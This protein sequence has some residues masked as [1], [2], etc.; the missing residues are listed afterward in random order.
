MV[1]DGEAKNLIMKQIEIVTLIDGTVHSFNFPSL[2]RASLTDK[3][4][5]FPI[6]P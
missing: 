1:A 3:A 4:L 6:L 5:K 2:Q